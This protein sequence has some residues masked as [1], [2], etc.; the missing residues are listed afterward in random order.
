MTTNTKHT[1]G[2]WSLRH[3]GRHD[4]DRL[5]TSGGSDICR[6]DGGPND[7]SETLAN[8]RLIAAAP[9]LLDALR[10]LLDWGRDHTSPTQPNSPHA[11]LVAAHA[12]IAN[13][14]GGITP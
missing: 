6:M 3:G 13:A 10:N 4:G 8:A 5:V 2:P 11:L 1:P 9:E 14:T 7:D 12:A